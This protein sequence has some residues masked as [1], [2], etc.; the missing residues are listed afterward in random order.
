[1]E[2]SAQEV[3]RIR[4]A[5]GQINLTHAPERVEDFI[6]R[7]LGLNPAQLAQYFPT[8]DPMGLMAI[9]VGHLTKE[10]ENIL[11]GE[12]R[13]PTFTVYNDA[14]Q[15]PQ[16][17]GLSTYLSNKQ[18]DPETVSRLSRHQEVRTA[19]R[20]MGD[21]HNLEAL[22]AAIMNGECDY[23]EATRGSGD[24]GIDAIGW[25]E[26]MLIEPALSEGS[27]DLD[28]ALPG[29]KVFL[30]ASSKALTSGKNR[31][32]KLINPAHI[33]ELVGGWVIQ[34]SSAGMWRRLGIRMLTPVQM[35]LVTTY[36]LS[37]DAKADCRTLGVQVWGIPELIYLVCRTAPPSVFD[38]GNGHAFVPTA[39]RSWW[40]QRNQ[41]RLMAAV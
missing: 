2:L 30:F 15:V 7:V 21:G 8:P 17:S 33:R 3:R 1:M 25:K 13:V 38:P 31:R 36:R 5:A 20:R 18:V 23:G 11:I 16:I 34:R 14:L 35:I 27:I 22:A 41:T 28:E 32:P 6:G 26:L 24:Q 39:F 19:L 4:T 10:R 37:P 29:E 9:A 12:C 40:R